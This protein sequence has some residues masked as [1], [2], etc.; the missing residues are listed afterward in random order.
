MLLEPPLLSHKGKISWAVLLSPV[1]LRTQFLMVGSQ[2]DPYRRVPK[3]RDSIFTSGVRHKG[4]WPG[5]HGTHTCYRIELT[6]DMPITDSPLTVCQTNSYSEKACLKCPDEH[7]TTT[8]ECSVE[9]PSFT[10]CVVDGDFDA[11]QSNKLH[12][13]PH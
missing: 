12:L 4:R 10:T 9:A 8:S 3:P 2:I 5:H 6:E 7:D 13:L 11:H 1:T